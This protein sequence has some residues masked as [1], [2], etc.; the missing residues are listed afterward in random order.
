L[1]PERTTLIWRPCRPGYPRTCLRATMWLLAS[2]LRQSSSRAR[3]GSR[4]RTKCPHGERRGICSPHSHA[5][6]AR[7]EGSPSHA[8]ARKRACRSTGHPP[9]TQADVR[10]S[11]QATAQIRHPRRQRQRYRL[12][13]HDA[14]RR[15][16]AGLAPPVAGREG[17]ALAREDA[18]RHGEDHVVAHR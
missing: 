11:A 4:V 3:C 5:T 13:L 14:S 8:R 15:T 2:K 6:C 16:S 10:L 18:R 7:A 17:R 1:S 12:P 9:H